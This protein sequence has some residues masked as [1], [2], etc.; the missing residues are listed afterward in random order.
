M[1]PLHGRRL[2]VVGSTGSGKSTLARQLAEKLSAV[3]IDLDNLHWEPN[4]TEAPDDV[5]RERVSA[6]IQ[7]ESW[8]VAG[9]YHQVRDLVWPHADT[10]IWLDYAFLVV[11]GRLIRRTL[12]RMVTREAICNGNRESFRLIFL[13]KDSIILWLFQSYWR[14]R[15]KY[16]LL[17][18]EPGHAHLA[19][20]RH[21]G[22]IETRRWL[23]SMMSEHDSVFEEPA[24]S[25]GKTSDGNA[26]SSS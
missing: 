18:A 3:W 22:P 5:F 25:E 7:Q 2:V 16:P 14:N 4:W 19:V 6:A 9:N 20:M 11:L 1:E 8:V 26:Q 24:A 12:W 13:S 15:R 21:R 10:I 23:A 17:F